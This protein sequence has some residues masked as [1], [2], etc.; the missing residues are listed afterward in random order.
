MKVK[1]D[2]EK[3]YEEFWKLNYYMAGQYDSQKGFEV[4]NYELKKYEEA[5]IL[6][7]DCFTWL[8]HRMYLKM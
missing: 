3:K 5:T 2:E 7:I 1:S 8:Y 4:L 6:L